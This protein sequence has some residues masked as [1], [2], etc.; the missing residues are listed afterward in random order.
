MTRKRTNSRNLGLYKLNKALCRGGDGCM[1]GWSDAPP[2]AC[3]CPHSTVHNM[4]NACIMPCRWE[5]MEMLGI[6]CQQRRRAINT[7]Q[8]RHDSVLRE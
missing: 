5:G 6:K 4:T 2:R 8:R 7:E 1:Y 3:A